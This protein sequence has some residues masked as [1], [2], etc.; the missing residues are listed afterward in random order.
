M[1]RFHENGGDGGDHQQIQ[2][3]ADV[4]AGVHQKGNSDGMGKRLSQN[5]EVESGLAIVAWDAETQG[6][7]RVKGFRRQKKI[8]VLLSQHLIVGAQDNRRTQA[9]HG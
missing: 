2:A 5:V 9:G 6:E 4:T 8:K 7:E 3:V 1:A